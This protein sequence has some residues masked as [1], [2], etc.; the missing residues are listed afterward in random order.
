[1]QT[2][3]EMIK[4]SLC[5]AVHELRNA[6]GI[7]LTSTPRNRAKLQKY[8]RKVKKILDEYFPGERPCE[9]CGALATCV[10]NDGIDLCQVCG[11]LD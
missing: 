8:A 3:E 9:G 10:D 5:R 4:E 7:H 1:M 2:Q 11:S 6:S